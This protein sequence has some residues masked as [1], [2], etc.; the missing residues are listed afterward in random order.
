MFE[1][2]SVGIKLSLTNNV[3]AGLAYL[4]G[5]FQRL[6]SHIQSSEQGLN[7]MEARLLR[8]QRLGLVGGVLT[9]VGAFGLYALKGPYEEAK[10]LEQAK[11]DFRALNLTKSEN[12]QAFA[13]AAVTS[14]KVLGTTITEN[15]RLVTDLHTAFGD[16]HHA[17]EYA[18]AFAKFLAVAK[19]RG[20]EHAGD[21]LVYNAVKALEHRGGKVTG[22]P[23]AFDDELSRM[24]QVYVGSGGRVGPA[25]YFHAS[26]T[27]KLAYSLADKEFLYGPFAAY[28]Q[29]KSGSTAATA[30]MTAYSSLAG[31]HMDGKAKAFM[32]SLGLA[33]KDGKGLRE[34]LVGEYSSRPDL[35]IQNVLTPAIKKRYGLNLTDEQIAELIGRNFNRNT[36]DFLG[37]FILNHQKALKD[38]A[39]FGHSQTYTAAYDAY[40]KTP[41]GAEQAFSSGMTNLKAIIGTA[42]LPMIVDGLTKLAPA[43]MKLADWAREHQGIVKALAVATALAAGLAVVSGTM[44]LMTS[45]IRAVGLAISMGG[46]LPGMLMGVADGLTSLAASLGKLGAVGA[47]GY[48]GYKLGEHVV[49][50]GIDWLVTKATG[51]ENTLGTALFNAFHDESWITA[52]TRTNSQYVR[53]RTF[54]ED[55]QLRTTINIDGRKVAEAVTHH[56]GKES[57]RPTTGIS[58]FDPSMMRQPLFM[59]S[60]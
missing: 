24:S 31:G 50:P 34:D 10:R 39:I 8:L 45:A 37:W 13:T 60:K 4:I 33:S 16:L 5:H 58:G 11:A 32:Q 22:S 15:V 46:G 20:G 21:G 23:G 36:G 47:V 17:I 41:E 38:A 19:V 1:A 49:K 30:M 26:Q 25:D 28:M 43:L 51:K 54:G 6:N 53:G 18:P 2:Y 14:Q 44:A 29:A 35:F 56:Q 57:A 9:G 55:H 42:Y 52:P 27:G 3:S 59:G 7:S 12:E 48:A 40:R